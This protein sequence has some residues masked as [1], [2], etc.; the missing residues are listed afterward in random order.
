VVVPVAATPT[1]A[2]ITASPLAPGILTARANVST[3]SADPDL[4]NNSA[5]TTVDVFQPITIDVAPRDNLNV[6]NLKRGGI[7]DV[8]IL[9]TDALDASAVDATSVC[10]GDAEAPAE[11]TCVEVHGRGHLDDVNRD[12][13]LD[14]VLHFD[15]SRTGIDL[16]DTK[17]C[18]IARTTSGTGVY[19]CEVISPK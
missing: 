11:R 9:T 17:A 2:T 14:L 3:A 19:A 8:A 7:V 6:L 13:R 5:S 12:R 4:T 10:F 1:I 18:L 15:L 16:V